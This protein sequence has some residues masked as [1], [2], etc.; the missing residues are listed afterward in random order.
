[1][2]QA[3]AHLDKFM[4]VYSAL[5]LEERKLPV[6]VIGD[7]PINWDMAHIE[8]RGNTVLGANIAEKLTALKII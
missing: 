1:M 3:R 5:P 4:K 8:I 2:A 7:E 6:V